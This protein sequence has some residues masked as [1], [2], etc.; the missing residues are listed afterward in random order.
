LQNTLFLP[1]KHFNPSTLQN[2]VHDQEGTILWT[3][4]SITV[5]KNLK[6][7][8]HTETREGTCTLE[9][10]LKKHFSFMHYAYIQSTYT[11]SSPSQIMSVKCGVKNQI[12]IDMGSSYNKDPRHKWLLTDT[13]SSTSSCSSFSSVA[14][15][16]HWKIGASTIL[17]IAHRSCNSCI[18]QVF[19]KI[20]Q[21]CAK[22]KHVL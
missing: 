19:L 17:L 12:Q 10:Q 11:V 22:T 9:V 14:A 18:S 8:H 3:I 15:K 4:E 6:C 5:H 21:L 13:K 1:E 20:R 2:T 16:G 7:A